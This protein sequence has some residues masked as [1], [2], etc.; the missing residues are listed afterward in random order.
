MNVN[1]NMIKRL[2]ANEKPIDF[3]AK[4]V[5]ISEDLC[6]KIISDLNEEMN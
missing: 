3:I 2:L 6:C 1:I 5:G 4:Q